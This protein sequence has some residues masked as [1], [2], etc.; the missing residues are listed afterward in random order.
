M[1][2]GPLTRGD[3]RHAHPAATAAG[4]GQDS[5][6]AAVL[7]ALLDSAVRFSRPVPVL[8][9]ARLAVDEARAL[10]PSMECIV[11][12]V[13]A[14]SPSF[15]QVVAD[16]RPRGLPDNQLQP[17][18]GSWVGLALRQGRPVDLY[19]DE[20]DGAAARP[21][22]REG[23]G[24]VRM[25]PLLA[26]A[27]LERSN[28]GLGVIGF[29]RRDPAPF[30][31]FEKMVCDELGRQLAQSVHAAEVRDALNQR[32]RRL[33]AGIDVAMD[34]ATR[35]PDAAARQ[36]LRR[37]VHA[38]DADRGVLLAVSGRR[39]VVSH[40]HGAR[41]TSVARG[42]R[43]PRQGGL[44]G[45]SVE[46]RVAVLGTSDDRSLMPEPYRQ[47]LHGMRH[48][49]IIPLVL[50]GEL[51]A[52]MLVARRRDLQVSPDDVSVLQQIGNIAGLALRSNR[53]LREATAAREEA[54]RTARRLGLGID[55]AAD[56]ASSL[57][58]GEVGTRL[59][60]HAA[61][62][63]EADRAVLC[64]LQ[65][66]ELVVE[67]G[68]AVDG[69]SADAASSHFPLREDGFVA[70]SL[71]S[72]QP[73]TASAPGT[74]LG[75]STY[76]GQTL[77]RLR[78]GLSVPLVLGGE[79]TGALVLWRS[80]DEAFAPADVAVA[81]TIA[82][83]AVLALENARMFTGV[84]G[85]SAAKTMFLNMAAHE[86]RT[87]LTV[88]AGYLAMLVDGSVGP[89]AARERVYPMMQRKTDELARLVDGLLT[90]ARLERKSNL[91]S[92]SRPVD[93]SRAARAAVNRVRPRADLVGARV[94]LTAPEGEMLALAEEDSLARILDNLLNNALTYSR[95]E[96]VVSVT[97]TT[98]ETIDV[99]V[100]DNGLGIPE[101][102]REAIF[103]RLVRVDR[104]EI[105][106]PPGTGLGL[107][108]SRELA[109]GI[110][111]ELVLESSAVD[112]GSVFKLSLAPVGTAG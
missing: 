40:I 41:G 46:A 102:Q 87:P 95:G 2:D 48:F 53:L 71:R 4:S 74:T 13:G 112:A 68:F 29:M 44:V 90:A 76:D 34:L 14:E 5:A 59:L 64:R 101:D 106:Y 55:V 54:T 12:L 24:A 51:E 6:A 63:V 93:A 91:G 66:G 32:A 94:E 80:T 70:Q 10:L 67:S 57:D 30:S 18:E 111:G 37:A 26:E 28:R 98:G 17:I 104:P 81:Q 82:N 103:E 79:T 78:H 19:R 65:D 86:L 92:E 9:L 43:A 77:R 100:A 85:A 89:E 22:F 83:V 36:L 72:R 96:P 11:G 109:R 7:Q 97:V 58:P 110:G 16:S 69:A 73:V 99:R 8:E 1:Q 39:L 3:V 49:A 62:A 84:E 108:I 107:Y 105:G 42:S 56:L 27:G 15:I 75:L 33:Q 47:L 50:G 38:A 52:V 61:G 45:A 23:A 88:I 31:D 60:A 25:V 21:W 35:E 20:A